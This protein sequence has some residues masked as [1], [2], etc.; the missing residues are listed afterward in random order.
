MSKADQSRRRD[1]TE[2]AAEVF[3]ERGYSEAT[4]EEIAERAGGDVAR[5][6]NLFPDKEAVLLA[7][8]ESAEVDLFERARDGCAGAG[9]A[10]EERVELTLLALL[11]WVDERRPLARTCLLET[12]R[13]TPVVFERRSLII[14]RLAALLR[15][16]QPQLSDVPEMYE[17]L[18]VGGICEVLSMKVVAGGEAA[19]VDLA[20]QLTELLG[21]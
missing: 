11:G 7:L 15:A 1:L 20:P 13:A 21:L 8:L 14:D 3:A 4:V 18:L 16:N 6:H 19:A 12:Q 5:L 2:A 10:P 9:D 17:Q